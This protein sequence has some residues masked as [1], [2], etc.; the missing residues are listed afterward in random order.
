MNTKQLIAAVAVFAA[1]GSAFAIDGEMPL[2]QKNFVSTKTRAEVTAEVIQARQQGFAV[3]GNAYEKVTNVA[4][5]GRTRAEVKAELAQAVKQ[6]Y[7][8]GGEAYEPVPAIASTRTRDEV[9]A[10]AI[11]AARNAN[12]NRSGS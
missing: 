8:V 5:T 11:Q 4:S 9:R 3:G 6:G 2:E 1:A 7:V 10:E 12:A